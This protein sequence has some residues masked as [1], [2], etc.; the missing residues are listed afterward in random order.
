MP[1]SIEARLKQGLIEE[2]KCIICHKI[3]YRTKKG[4]KLPRHATEIRP[5]NAR[6][7]GKNCTRKYNTQL[8]SHQRR[9]LIEEELNTPPEILEIIRK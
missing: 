5:W 4:K 1:L 6:T 7:C 9:E 3:F 8:T 2:I